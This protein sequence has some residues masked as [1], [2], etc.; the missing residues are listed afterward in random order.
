MTPYWSRLTILPPDNAHP[1]GSARSW[2]PPAQ[3]G[4]PSTSSTRSA[5][6]AGQPSS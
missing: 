1:V 6:D 2:A 4:R 3:L 5:G